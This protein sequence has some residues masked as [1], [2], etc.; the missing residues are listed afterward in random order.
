M[1]GQRAVMT[2]ENHVLTVRSLGQCIDINAL[3]IRK[4]YHM[5]ERVMT[6]WREL[7]VRD[8]V[9]NVCPSLSTLPRGSKGMGAPTHTSCHTY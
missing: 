3:Y 7:G 6:L 9:K 8:T 1:V 5:S 4:F 2:C